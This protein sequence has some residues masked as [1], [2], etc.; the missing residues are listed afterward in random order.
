MYNT[1]HCD[2]DLPCVHL[3]SINKNQRTII[4]E[5]N[6]KFFFMIKHKRTIKLFHELIST[7][8]LE[9]CYCQIALYSPNNTTSEPLKFSRIS[10]WC[11]VHISSIVGITYVLWILVKEDTDYIGNFKNLANKDNF[12]KLLP[13]ANK[14]AE[15]KTSPLWTRLFKIG[16]EH[17]LCATWLFVHVWNC[18]IH[19]I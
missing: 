19:I 7:F 17:H 11:L 5:T 10:F 13:D 15:N 9:G 2:H 18:T 8:L 1:E 14:A 4:D 12:W 6:Y 16:C 3:L